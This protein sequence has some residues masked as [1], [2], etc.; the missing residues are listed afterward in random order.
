M[1]KMILG[2][3]L[4][5]TQIFAD[6]GKLIPVTVVQAGP[7]VVVA[8]KSKHGE[9]GYAAV[10]VG[11][12]DA[13]KQEKDGDVRYRGLTRAQAGVFLKLGIEPK[14][15]VREFRVDEGK[16]DSFQVG[17]I[18]DASM[19]AEGEFIDVIGVS[20]GRGFTG[21]MKRHNFSGFKNSHGVH[22][23]H[24][25]GGSI[26]TSA[27][28]SRVFPGLKMAGRHGGTRCTTQ[29]L[30]IVRV[31]AEDSLYLIRGAV[32]GANGG[33]VEV[34]PSVKRTGGSRPR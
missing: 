27:T 21:V 31:I 26:G 10:K 15:F 33:I 25:G 9:D 19:F 8:R 28:P 12:E 24:R 1:S 14:R 6:D 20:K 18:L 11:Y 13:R 23:S 22:E 3:K 5:M 17:Q 30:K 2:R 29:G 16:L 32:P 34:Y 4:G 7:M